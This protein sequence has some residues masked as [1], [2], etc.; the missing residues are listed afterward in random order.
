MP[1]APHNCTSDSKG[2]TQGAKFQ[3]Q[4]YGQGRRVFTTNKTG[5]KSTCTVCGQK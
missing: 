5:D 1:I 4:K 2:N 3:D